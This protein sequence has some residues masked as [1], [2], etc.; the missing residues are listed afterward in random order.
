[1]FASRVLEIGTVKV[2]RVLTRI[3][4]ERQLKFVPQGIF[5]S[6]LTSISFSHVF[7]SGLK[8]NFEDSF[9]YDGSFEN[10]VASKFLLVSIKF[11]FFTFFVCAVLKPLDIGLR[12]HEHVILSL[13]LSAFCPFVGVVIPGSEPAVEFV[14][15]LSELLGLVW[16]GNVCIFRHP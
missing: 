7:L 10:L 2:Y 3:Y 4:P 11:F 1:M 6:C 15:Q 8:L 9:V 5:F 13:S 12:L 14:D 16:N